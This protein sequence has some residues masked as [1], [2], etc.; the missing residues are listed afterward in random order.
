LQEAETDGDVLLGALS[1][2]GLNVAEVVFSI[3]MGNITKSDLWTIGIFFVGPS[4]FLYV[5]ALYLYWRKKGEAAMAKGAII[6]A[7]VI[8]LLN[9]CCWGLFSFLNHE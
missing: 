9:V 1:V 7:C 2:F 6:G 8:L 3:W 4:Q 5:V